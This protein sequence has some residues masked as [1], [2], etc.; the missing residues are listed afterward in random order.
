G[1][2]GGGGPGRRTNY[3]RG[4]PNLFRSNRQGAK[5]VIGQQA[6]QPKPVAAGPGVL[7][8]QKQK[9]AEVERQEP[10]RRKAAPTP[11]GFPDKLESGTFKGRD[12]TQFSVRR[13]ASGK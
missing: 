11:E 8:Q 13:R 6:A 12:G 10:Q 2:P 3:E 4:E 7:G 5:P 1:G 9:P